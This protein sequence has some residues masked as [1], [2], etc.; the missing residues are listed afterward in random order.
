[1]LTLV[2]LI[3]VDFNYCQSMDGFCGSDPVCNK[4]IGPNTCD[5]PLGFVNNSTSQN[6]LVPVCVGEFNHFSF[7]DYFTWKTLTDLWATDSVIETSNTEELRFLSVNLK[8]LS[9]TK[10][11]PLQ[12]MVLDSNDEPL[13]DLKSSKNSRV[14]KWRVAFICL[15]R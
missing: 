3:F 5:C 13:S 7:G 4:S 10:D 6:P 12:I 15:S 1:M 9:F 14:S 11:P 8:Y 2:T